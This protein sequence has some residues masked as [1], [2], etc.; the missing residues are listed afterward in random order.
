MATAHPLA[1]AA[2]AEVLEAGGTAADAAAASM[3]ALGVVS[4]A[5][6]GLGGGGFALYYDAEAEQLT[7]LD[8]RET[9]PAA[10]TPDMFQ[11]DEAE[12]GDSRSQAG[13]LS[14]AIP[15]EP[16]GIEELLKRFGN[17]PRQTV[18][19]PA[20]RL[21]SQGFPVGP[22][23]ARQAGF[24]TE[25]LREDPALGR[26]FEG[27]ERLEEGQVVTQ[28]ELARTLRSFARHGAEPFYRGAI[29]RAV[30]AA[31]QQA[32]G[33]ITR[34]DMA[35][36]TIQEREPLA[37]ER[38][39]Y[40][41][42]T[43]PLPSAGGYTILSSL[44]LLERWLPNA[45][46]PRDGAYL[47]ALLESWKGPYWDRAAYFGDADHVSVPLEALLAPERF[48]DRAAMFR[49]TLAMSFASYGFSIDGGRGE[50]LAP[51][52]DHGTSHLCVVDSAGNVAAV[53]T[54]V[55]YYF[56]ARYTARGMVM[57]N[58]MDDF[59][60]P[61]GEANLFGLVGGA[62]NAP[63]PGKRP[64][65]SMSPTI[66]FRDNK[67]VLCVGAAGGSR[68][69]TATQQVAMDILLRGTA[70]AEAIGAPRVHGQGIPNKVYTE[71][72][73]PLTD[74]LQSQLR[75]RGHALGEKHHLAIVNVIQITDDGLLAAGSPRAEGTAAGR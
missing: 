25:Q 75:G 29:A 74:D 48:L 52:N 42:V 66:V 33:V 14:T 63:S 38:F 30:V 54:T 71:T 16:A 6:S 18:A 15:G 46:G 53:T 62:Q 28:P 3:L 20:I 58:E 32:G 17:Q 35:G 64:I 5:S 59:S 26:W 65:S 23:L 21:A 19:A 60:L 10:A 27:R 51:A 24:F 55:N 7:F 50:P 73:M 31:N 61:E 11:R 13:G 4:G 70:P 68:I 40:R 72:V 47:H 12:A 49:P 67:P 2:G 39:G 57:N 9:A 1:S 44:A 37:G 22:T 34:S 69:P 43:A 41:W 45:S 56:G 36:Y 8:F